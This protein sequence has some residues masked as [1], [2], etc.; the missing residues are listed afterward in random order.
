M[1]SC[2][3]LSRDPA[4][5]H[6]PGGGKIEGLHPYHDTASI[7]KLQSFHSLDFVTNSLLRLSPLCNLFSRTT[8]TGNPAAVTSYELLTQPAHGSFCCSG[9]RIDMRGPLI[10]CLTNQQNS[11]CTADVDFG[12]SKHQDS[13]DNTKTRV[14]TLNARLVVPKTEQNSLRDGLPG[15]LA[16]DQDGLSRSRLRTR[17]RKAWD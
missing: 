1:D 14:S 7:A 4:P 9:P 10:T 2:R 13:E 8:V 3:V 12:K 16:I 17:N 5:N 6:D 11:G 15:Q